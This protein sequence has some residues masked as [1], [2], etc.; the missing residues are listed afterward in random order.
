[1]MEEIFSAHD[2]GVFI[3]AYAEYFNHDV[4]DKLRDFSVKEKRN[5]LCVEFYA[6]ACK[7]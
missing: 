6:Y 3:I 5:K 2:C 7:K 1:M 4:I